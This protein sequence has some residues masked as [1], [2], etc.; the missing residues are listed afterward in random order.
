MEI[1]GGEQIN[2]GIYIYLVQHVPACDS[3]KI[4]KSQYACTPSVHLAIHLTSG[5]AGSTTTSIPNNAKE[6]PQKLGASNACTRQHK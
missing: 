3:T 4:M 6:G 5:E 1:N 2:I